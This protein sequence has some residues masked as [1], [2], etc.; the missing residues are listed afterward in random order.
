MR[1]CTG[2]RGLEQEELMLFSR[3]KTDQGIAALFLNKE[4]RG[5]RGKQQVL[6]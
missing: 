4:E 2:E 3:S 6:S 1:V 5:G